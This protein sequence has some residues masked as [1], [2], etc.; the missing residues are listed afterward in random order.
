M[1]TDKEGLLYFLSATL[2]TSVDSHEDGFGMVAVSALHFYLCVYGQTFLCLSFSR[3][4][5][6]ERI[7]PNW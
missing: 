5:I 6:G 1:S 3:C 2:S 4:K 7:L